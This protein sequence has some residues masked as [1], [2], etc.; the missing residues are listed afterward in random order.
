MRAAWLKVM[1]RCASH[2]LQVRA[3]S[4]TSGMSVKAVIDTNRHRA[5][6]SRVTDCEV[7]VSWWQARQSTGWPIRTT[8]D[9]TNNSPL[10]QD[11][12]AEVAV[13]HLFEDA[14]V[15]S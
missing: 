4:T 8:G 13:Q 2:Q 7:I 1:F 9:L 14:A 6:R 5:I 15:R 10:P 11:F 3:S 12:V